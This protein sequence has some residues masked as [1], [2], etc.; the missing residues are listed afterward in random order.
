MTV[1][2]T[3]TPAQRQAERKRRA[4]RR[5]RQEAAVVADPLLRLINDTDDAC[6]CRAGLDPDNPWGWYPDE[7]DD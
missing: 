5:K 7:E 1:T 4:R 2:I 3:R 6:I